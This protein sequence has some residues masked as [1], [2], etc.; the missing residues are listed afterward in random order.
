MCFEW[1][2]RYRREQAERLSKEKVD[3]L[4]KR[5]QEAASAGQGILESSVKQSVNDQ[6]EEVTA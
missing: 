5:S 4:I 6:E 2:E 1:D 3:E